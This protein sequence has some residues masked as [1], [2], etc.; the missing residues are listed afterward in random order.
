MS[1][2]ESIQLTRDQGVAIIRFNRPDTLNA[3]TFD[4][5]H[6]LVRATAEL[7]QDDAVRCVVLTGQGRGFCSGGDVHGIIASLQ[8]MDT[9]GLLRF[10]HLTGAATLGLLNLK[11]PCIAAVNGIA[12]G[13]GAVLASACDM[14]LAARS[15]RFAFLFVRVGLTG[16]D[17]GAAYL[18]S[19]IVGLGRAAELLYTGDTIG[20]E[21]AYRIGLVNRVIDDDK[22][23]EEAMALAHKL[24]QGPAI[25]NRFTK[26][27]L[28]KQWTMDA[29]TAIEFDAEAQTLCMQTADHREGYRAFVE[30]RPPLFT[31]R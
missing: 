2:Y 19:R 24:A 25:A 12:A 17:M 18:L 26:E 15:A 11:K 4:T 16:A 22:L 8:E 7:A 1:S 5:Y 30:K 20:A 14:R 3:L 10:T 27:A 29:E 9:Q 31:G 6:E 28:L 23:E 21:E 13:A